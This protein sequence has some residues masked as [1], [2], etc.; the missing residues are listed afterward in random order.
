M[1][2]W[3]EDKAAA[4]ERNS[5]T[6]L[7]T[8][9]FES[10]APRAAKSSAVLVEDVIQAFPPT[11]LCDIKSPAAERKVSTRPDEDETTWI[12]QPPKEEAK[13]KVIKLFFFLTSG[14]W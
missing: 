7:F 11:L 4:N 5:E 8:D 10:V 6:Q 3:R 13:Y 2:T 9:Q 14:C 1:M 12:N